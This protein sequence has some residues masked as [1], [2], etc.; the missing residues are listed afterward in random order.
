MRIISGSRRGRRFDAPDGR[1]TRPTLDR[2]KEAMFGMLQFDIED[3]I[4]L[5][6]FAGSGNL[7]LEALSRG[8]AYAVFCDK[9]RTA[10]KL[11]EK[12]LDALGFSECAEVHCADCFLLLDRL[13]AG[14]KRFSLVLLDPPYAAGLTERVLD[15]LVSGEILST[16]CIIISEHSW[17]MPPDISLLSERTKSSL[18]FREPR[19]YGDVGVTYIYYKGE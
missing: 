12:N 19:R 17:S 8:A 13:A 9:S 2:V 14:K 15:K 6:L 16:G 10:A 18:V 7:G 11:V 5:D 3:R 1:E 4:V